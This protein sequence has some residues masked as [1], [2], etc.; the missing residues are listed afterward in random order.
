M[1]NL[2]I[3][4]A[5]GA[6]MFYIITIL[7][8]VFW[9]GLVP[10]PLSTVL[11]FEMPFIFIISGYA[12]S[13][14]ERTRPNF[15]FSCKQYVG[16]LM[17]RATRILVPYYTYTLMCLAIIFVFNLVAENSEFEVYDTITSWLNPFNYGR[18]YSLGALNWHLWFVAPFLSVTAFFPFCSFIAKLKFRQ[19]FPL[20]LTMLGF[21]LI[22]YVLSSMKFELAYFLKTCI[23]YFLWACFGYLLDGRLKIDRMQYV[24]VIL[25][26]IM[27]LVF[28]KLLFTISLD[29]QLNKFPPSWIFFLFSCAW[30]SSIMLILSYLKS[31]NL[32]FLA[33][34][35]LFSP[36]IKNGYSVYLWQGLGYTVATY[37][38]YK[39]NLPVYVVWVIAV[40]LTTT[41]GVIFSPFERI[42]FNGWAAKT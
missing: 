10:R 26:A 37:L 13:L 12:Y 25:T 32:K 41:M 15:V 9:L 2:N 42:R 19:K 7:H 5:R 31:H 29:M 39:I 11:L 21:T 23:F 27:L 16:F 3:D 4:I 17:S 20:W 33:S 18:G 28:F 35:R 30:V 36:F 22:I 24:F 14:Y 40:V 6:L 34:S 8:G 1:R 38:G